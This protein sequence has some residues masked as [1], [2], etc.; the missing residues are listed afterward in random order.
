M[1]SARNEAVR[2]REDNETEME[3]ACEKADSKYQK[4][5]SSLREVTLQYDRSANE[6]LCNAADES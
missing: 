6:P 4:L 1:P 2:I 3:P 5:N